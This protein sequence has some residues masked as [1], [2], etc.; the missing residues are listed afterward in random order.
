M[1]HQWLLWVHHIIIIRFRIMGEVI[2]ILGADIIIHII[3]DTL[4]GIDHIIMVEL[5]IDLTL[6]TDI[7]EVQEGIANLISEYHSRT[8]SKTAVAVFYFSKSGRR[9]FVRSNFC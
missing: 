3:P 6:G 8:N 7:M 1:R 9:S 2:F 5:S 4:G